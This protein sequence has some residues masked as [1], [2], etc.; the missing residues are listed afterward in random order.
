VLIAGA[1][2]GSDGNTDVGTL[3]AGEPSATAVADPPQEQATSPDPAPPEPGADTTAGAE[4]DQ[5]VGAN[6]LPAVTVRDIAT[7]DDVDLSSFAPGELPFVV[8]FWAPH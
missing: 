1:C 6:D 4:P 3:A 2:G 8:W 5:P 7:G